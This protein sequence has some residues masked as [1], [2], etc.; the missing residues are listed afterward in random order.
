MLAV[1]ARGLLLWVLLFNLADGLLTWW[2]VK[3]G[4]AEEA[5]PLMRY[6]LSM[7]P[8]S[9]ALAKAVLVCAGVCVLW[10][11]RSF[12]LARRGTALVFV[13]YAALMCFHG[14]SVSRLW[15]IG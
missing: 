8:L 3:L 4:I 5:N 14:Q 9:F 15:S 12:P 1:H 13:T 10:R 2:V 11:F 6:A 7:G